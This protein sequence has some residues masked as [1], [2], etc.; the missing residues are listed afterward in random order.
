MKI[1]HNKVIGKILAVIFGLAAA[2]YFA[3]TFSFFGVWLGERFTS[4]VPEAPNVIG[5]ICAGVMF[6]AVL[7]SFFYIEYAREDVRA[8]EI[9]RGDGTFM[10]ALHQLKI[11]VLG[12]EGF[13]LI[14]RLFQ[15]AYGPGNLPENIALGLAM[16]GVGLAL[17]WLAH[18]FGKVLHAQVNA[19]HDVE[20]GRVMDEAGRRVWQEAPRLMKKMNADQLRRLSDGDHSPLDEVLDSEGREREREVSNAEKRAR[21]DQE[22]REKQRGLNRRFLAPRSR[23]DPFDQAHESVGS[24]QGQNGR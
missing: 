16:V 18:L 6:I 2:G 3:W 8:Y 24:H 20:A 11:A 22:R 7:F 4:V 5:L 12:L 23:S 21:E 17:L 10:R 9:D 1:F 19:P 15:L 14:F 13:S